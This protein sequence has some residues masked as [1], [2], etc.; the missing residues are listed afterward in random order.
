MAYQAKGIV[1]DTLIEGPIAEHDSEAIVQF[2]QYLCRTY[3][4]SYEFAESMIE[5]FHVFLDGHFVFN[6]TVKD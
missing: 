1:F 6:A 3:G 4:W 5:D 2:I